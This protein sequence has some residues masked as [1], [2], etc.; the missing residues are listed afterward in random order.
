MMVM[1]D[2]TEGIR[3]THSPSGGGF[4]AMRQTSNPAWDFQFIIPK[5]EVN[6]DYGFKGR[7][8]YRPKCSRDEVMKEYESW[9]KG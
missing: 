5:Y 7:L 1:L 8:V 9:K 3:F 4:N 2:R 6:E